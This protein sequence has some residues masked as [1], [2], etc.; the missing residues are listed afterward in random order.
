MGGG[1]KE[2]LKKKCVLSTPLLFVP[3]VLNSFLL[4]LLPFLPLC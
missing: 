1:E 4:S 3:V 2:G